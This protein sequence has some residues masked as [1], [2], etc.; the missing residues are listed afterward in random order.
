MDLGG[1][2]CTTITVK[3]YDNLK[4]HLGFKGDTRVFSRRFQTVLVAEELQRM[5]HCDVRVIPYRPS[6]RDRARST[7][8]ATYTDEW[9][10]N[11]QS[12]GLYFNIIN[13]PLKDATLNDLE[14]YDW[15][16][17]SDTERVKGVAEEAQVLA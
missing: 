10:L 17:P 9:G 2:D 12:D 13:S 7:T 16:D 4:E 14:G 6:I 3:A 11:Y 15:P 8:G 1:S 5:L